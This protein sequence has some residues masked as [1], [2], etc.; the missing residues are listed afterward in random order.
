MKS[1]SPAVQ[2]GSTRRFAP[3]PPDAPFYRKLW[4][5]W[6]AVARVIGDILSRIVT[7]LA[8]FVLLPVFALGM[9]L[10]SDPLELKPRPPLWIP[11]PPPPS[12]VDEAR[13]GF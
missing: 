13:I 2:L 6:Q 3:L 12:N 4:R 10:F 5:A 1:S 7:S 11:L 8:F 9:R